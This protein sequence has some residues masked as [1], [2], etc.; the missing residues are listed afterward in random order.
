MFRHF[1]LILIATLLF[2]GILQREGEDASDAPAHSRPTFENPQSRAQLQFRQTRSIRTG[3][4]PDNI[5][6]RELTF[7]SDRFRKS[8]TLPRSSAAALEWHPRG[9][10]N[11]GGRTRAFAIDVTN[12]NTLL[13]GG[14]S[15]GMWRSEDGG[16]S[17]QKT[18]AP[19]LPQNVS[20][21]A[22]DTR[23]GKTHV[24]YFGTGELFGSSR[25]LAGAG[26]F[27]SEDGGRSWQPLPSSPAAADSGATSGVPGSNN[28][29]YVRISRIVVNP[30]VEDR[31]EL[32]VAS[33][34]GLW[35]SE[36]GGQSWA[37]IIRQT[38]IWWHFNDILVT[39]GSGTFYATI[40]G[41][42]AQ[43]VWRS[44]DGRNWTDITSGSTAISGGYRILI[45]A[46]PSNDDVVYFLTADGGLTKY[47]YLAGD[48]SGEGGRWQ[49]RTEVVQ[50][51]GYGSYGG[52]CVA[53]AIKPD[54][55]N[56]V[57]L[58]G[59]RTW[60]STDGFRTSASV[61]NIGR[62]LSHHPDQH[63]L[64]FAHSNPNLLYAAHDG[65]LSRT[66]APLAETVEWESLE[67]GYRTAQF[68]TI[69]ID[70]SSPGDSTLI[71][72]MQDNGT[73]FVNSNREAANWSNITGGDGGYAAIAKD[74]TYYYVSYQGGAIL[75][76]EINPQGE[77]ADK[78]GRETRVDPGQVILSHRLF[79][80]PF[81]LNPNNTNMM[82]YPGLYLW[83]NH[84][85]TAIPK[86]ARNTTVNWERLD[87]TAENR[88]VTA[89]E[90]ST[91]PPNRLYYARQSGKLYRLDDA[92]VGNPVPENIDVG[93]PISNSPYSWINSIAVDRKDAD[94][95]LVA[96]SNYES[97]SVFATT[98]GGHT[99][100][101]VSGNLEERPDGTGGGPSVHAVE[102]LNHRGNVFY[103]VG[104][105]V[106]IFVTEK[107]DGH[108]TV[109]ELETIGNVLVDMIDSRD[110]D[111][112]V[113][114]ATHGN[115]VY[116][117]HVTSSTP[118]TVTDGS[119]RPEDFALAQNYPNPF[120]PVTTIEYAV[121]EQLN[122][123]ITIFDMQGRKVR[124]LVNQQ[125]P[126]GRYAITW[127]GRNEEGRLAASGVYIYRIQAGA[128]RK[129][130]KMILMK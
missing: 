19:D 129:N 114:V 74:K 87:H 7:V 100:N 101:D 52:Y 110:E 88:S 43:R 16:R 50:N 79:R 84:D 54:D 96:V 68:Y 76:E 46:A 60:R 55:E 56:V 97:P 111:G 24:W 5:R 106:G 31:D 41:N 86:F 35:R 118:T 120:N 9:P 116:S 29:Y 28:G 73:Y 98:D 94:R 109:W 89:L 12:E 130:R 36:D 42:S 18:T 15:G 2:W 33:D 63:V 121:P 85:L 72:G 8:N 70:Q 34:H 107:L 113:V 21:L 115:G 69:A 127:D 125:K 4:I 103:F 95:V 92:H 23:P 78:R 61:T 124:T 65:G 30:R 108:N 27:K 81:V 11:V 32:Y 119:R 83:R 82:F 10:Y 58:G 126:P 6:F 45:A 48:G 91:E 47:T 38:D 104:T 93:F 122:V 22:Q 25:G 37:P 117:T 14:A 67:N 66:N 57:F 77:R 75:R 53:I 49:D 123:T 128:L 17:W 112:L 40:Y 51:V 62:H 105:T 71:G 99:W 64:V 59:V 39:P 13:A 1:I 90:M 102:I 20:C 80:H 3:E 26:I 44:V